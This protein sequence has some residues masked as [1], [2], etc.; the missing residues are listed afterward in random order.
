MRKYYV[1]IHINSITSQPFYVGKGEGYRSKRR[2]GRSKDWNDIVSKYGYVI[3]IIES[4]LSEIESIQREKHY[5]SLYGRIDNKTG[6]LINKTSGGNYGTS[7]RV[8]TNDE[9]RRISD[10]LKMKYEQGILKKKD[11]KEKI[12]GPG[13]GSNNPHKGRFRIQDELVLKISKIDDY[14]IAC[15]TYNICPATFYKMKKNIKTNN[16]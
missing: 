4:G 12:K 13:S 6:I 15:E 9:R 7:G 5:I 16:V 2:S 14:K 3:K 1:Y 8:V 11:K 10:T